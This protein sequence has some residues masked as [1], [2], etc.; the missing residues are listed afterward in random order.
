MRIKM[1]TLAA[2]KHGVFHPGKEYTVTDAVGHPMVDGGY[3]SL[4]AEKP[5]TQILPTA[6]KVDQV[7]EVDDK[8]TPIADTPKARNGRHKRNK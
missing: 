7:E 3:A 1:R 2:G 8:Q 6:T 5:K 4:I